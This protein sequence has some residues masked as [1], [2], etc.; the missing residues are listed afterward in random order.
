MFICQYCRQEK[1]NANSHRNHERLCK[2]NPNRQRSPFEDPEIQRTRVKSNAAIKGTAKPWTN[3]QREHARQVSLTRWTKEK[4]KEQSEKMKSVMAQAVQ[5]HPESYSYKNFCGRS[6]KTIYNGQ[7]LHSSWGL[8]VAQ[9][10]DTQ[11]IQWTRKV[12]G[13]E[14][15][16]QGSRKSYFPDFYLPELDVYLE[17][18]GYETDKDR[19]KWKSIPGLIVIKEKEIKII[20]PETYSTR[21]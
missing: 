7:W 12:P 15:I 19:E 13:F 17:V 1:K 10:L 3:S 2:S 5:N 11:N 8:L 9:W 4:R 14:Y 21:G 18:K 6:K 16:W 20:Q